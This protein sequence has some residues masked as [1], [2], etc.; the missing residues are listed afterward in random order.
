L[1]KNVTVCNTQFRFACGLYFPS[2]KWRGKFFRMFL[3][4]CECPN[5]IYDRISYRW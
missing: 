4:Y 3:L 2:T 5:V 1:D